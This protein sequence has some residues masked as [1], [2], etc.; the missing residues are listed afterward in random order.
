M[1]IGASISIVHAGIVFGA[2]KFHIHPVVSNCVVI[3]P[4][5]TMGYCVSWKD[6]GYA[7]LGLVCNALM[8]GVPFATRVI[9]L[10]FSNK[11]HTPV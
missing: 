1:D 6:Q 8:L 4:N 7:V 11:K 3:V 10:S 9:Q 5:G 2:F